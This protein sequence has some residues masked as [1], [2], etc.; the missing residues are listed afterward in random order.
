MN[1]GERK[2]DLLCAREPGACPAPCHPRSTP[3]KLCRF[4]ILAKG[5]WRFGNLCQAEHQ[6]ADQGFTP[7]LPHS[8]VHPGFP[9][10]CSR[11]WMQEEHR[12]RTGFPP[13]SRLCWEIRHPGLL[14]THRF[15]NDTF[16]LFI[17]P[18]P[19]VVCLGAWRHCVKL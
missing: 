12:E 19:M 10:P 13:A 5:T 7:G 3:S 1:G 8:R 6:V 11:L 2:A 18:L 9:H 14:L 15:L 4:L 16:N 17:L